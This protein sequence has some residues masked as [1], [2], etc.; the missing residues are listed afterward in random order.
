[1]SRC[2]ERVTLTS[3]LIALFLIPLSSQADNHKAPALAES[4]VVT[5]KDGMHKEFEKAF[6]EHMKFRQKAGD[7]RAWQVYNPHTGKHMGSYII[8]YCCFNW[9]DRDDYVEWG[10]KQKISDHWDNNVDQY[11][12]EYGHEYSSIDHEN[13]NWVESKN[14]YK[15]IGVRSFKL[16]A[17][18]NV[19]DSVKAMSQLA[20]DIKWDRSW[21]WAYSVTGP[22]MLML[23][24]PFENFAAMQPPEV[25]FLKAAS[26]HLGS[27]EK[28]KEMFK[29]F[30]SNFKS[31]YYTIYSHRPELSMKREK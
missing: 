20:K 2:I 1:M 16:K 29:Q 9:A 3:F 12:A 13:G 18:A 15:Y 17:D 31:T 4:W 27:E 28:A 14:G 23:V 10:E 11:V 30:D 24:F 19:R 5:V 21:G 6:T 8:R 26:K 22:D 25:S 7:P